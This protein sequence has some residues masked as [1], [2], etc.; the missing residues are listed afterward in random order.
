[1]VLEMSPPE[2]TAPSPCRCPAPWR[3][4]AHLSD[5]A[6][7][8]LRARTRSCW[9]QPRENPSDQPTNVHRSPSRKKQHR[10][11]P[12]HLHQCSA[13]KLLRHGTRC[14]TSLQEHSS[15]SRSR[16]RSRSVTA[17]A[18]MKYLLLLLI[19]V[20]AGARG[21]YQLRRVFVQCQCCRHRNKQSKPEEKVWLHVRLQELMSKSFTTF[22]RGL[23]PLQ[24]H[25]ESIL[26]AVSR[27]C[28]ATSQHGRP[29]RHCLAASASAT[30]AGKPWK[31]LAD[32]QASA[33]WK[34]V[35]R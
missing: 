24:I 34:G 9:D 5:A 35:L 4:D 33:T 13:F 14:L 7:E 10:L 21:P 32:T 12:S 1:V 25:N 6:S 29:P 17:P 23:N 31:Y 3:V 20:T 15:R 28:R 27:R 30:I 18:A 8:A 2:F 26:R 19:C 22:H 11:R 16:S